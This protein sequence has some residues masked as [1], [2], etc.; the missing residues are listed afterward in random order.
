[1]SQICLS[2]GS[3]FSLYPTCVV[4][5]IFLLVLL[6]NHIKGF[7]EYHNYM[8][9]TRRHVDRLMQY[10]TKPSAVLASRHLRVLIFFFVHTSKA[11]L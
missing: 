11:V 4:V 3:V 2:G 7:I 1:M 8:Y 10:G 6:G 5:D 9:S